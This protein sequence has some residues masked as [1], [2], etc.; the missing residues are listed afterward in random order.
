MTNKLTATTTVNKSGREEPK[1]KTIRQKIRKKEYC[2]GNKRLK[3]EKF[4]LI[5]WN[6][7][8]TRGLHVNIV[9]SRWLANQEPMFR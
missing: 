4:V 5:T 1:A 9:I 3:T 6:Y 7:E 2:E 8:A